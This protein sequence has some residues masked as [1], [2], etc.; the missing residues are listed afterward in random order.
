MGAREL[1]DHVNDPNENANVAN[2][3]ENKEKVEQLAKMMDEGWEGAKPQ[4]TD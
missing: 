1:Y 4:V 3:A 2:R